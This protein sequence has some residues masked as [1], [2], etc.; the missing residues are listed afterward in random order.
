MNEIHQ[1]LNEIIPWLDFSEART[2]EVWLRAIPFAGLAL[3]FAMNVYTIA[4]RA[5]MGVFDWYVTS[6]LFVK[7]G[8]IL[9][10]GLLFLNYGFH[11]TAPSLL[12]DVSRLWLLAG[13]LFGIYPTYRYARRATTDFLWWLAER[14]Y[15]CHWRE[16][17]S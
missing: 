16:E 12:Y 7:T 3:Y 15:L 1:L 9:W 10:I 14:H 11:L 8:L 17:E 2:Q 4:L 5:V 13:A 6:Q